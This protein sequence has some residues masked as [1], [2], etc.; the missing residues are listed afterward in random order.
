M[1]NSHRAL[2]ATALFLAPFWAFAAAPGNLVKIPCPGGEAADH[3]C[4]AVYFYGGDGRRHA[5]PGERNYFTWY[6]NFDA[7]KTISENE[8]AAIPLGDNVTYRPG[9]KLVKFPTEDKVYA[10]AS[11]RTLRWV[12]SEQA[13][14]AM[15]GQDWAKKV[16]D[17]PDTFFGDYQ[18]GANISDPAGFDS[19]AEHAGAPTVDAALPDSYRSL[20]VAT[21][22]GTFDVQVVSL[23]KDRFAMTTDVAATFGCT[24]GCATKSLADYAAASGALIGVHGS[25]FCPPDYAACQGKTNTFNPPVFRSS[26]KV[27]FSPFGL[28]VHNGPMLAYMSDGK[29]VFMRLATDSGGSVSALES[30]QSAQLVAA[31]SNYPAL[32]QGGEVVVDTDPLLEDSQKTNKALRAGI[33]LDDKRLLIVV[34]KNATVPDLA[35]V[36]A[37]LGA[38]DALNLDGGGSTALLFGGA[39]KAGPGRTLPNAVLFKAR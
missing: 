35:A 14:I 21:A 32:M 33:G 26:D 20:K 18:F 17:I 39:Y 36:F 34:A 16:D 11:G 7:V 2:I 24:D 27:M 4:R 23:R 5:F 6:A 13:A 9:S 31:V 37:T 19:A 10:V 1:M 3:P 25:Y 22:R 15:A 38:K 30:R 29:F 28:Q 12:T 8:M